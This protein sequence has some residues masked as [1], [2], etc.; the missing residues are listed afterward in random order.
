MVKSEKRELLLELD[1]TTEEF[2]RE[3]L[4]LGGY[5]DDQVEVVKYWLSKKDQARADQRAKEQVVM[6]RST[7]WWTRATGLIGFGV[8][9]TVAVLN[10]LAK[11][12]P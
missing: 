2:I 1:H 11:N 5:M 9:L 12:G 8:T 4:A 3:K 7:A 6:T 10:W